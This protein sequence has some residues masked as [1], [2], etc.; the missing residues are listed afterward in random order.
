MIPYEPMHEPGPKSLLQGVV[1]PGGTVDEDIRAAIDHLFN[2]PNVGPFI[3]YRL[4]QR[5]VTS[6]PSPA[7]GRGWPARLMIMDREFGE[8]WER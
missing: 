6:N 4:I 1:I 5:L 8:T 2:H 7:Y 3:G